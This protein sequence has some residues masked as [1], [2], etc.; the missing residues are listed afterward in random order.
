MQSLKLGVSSLTVSRLAYGCWRIAG[1]PPSASPEQYAAGR[2]A[3]FAA[4]D[5][6]YTL[7]D[8]ADIYGRS[9]AE[10]ILGSALKENPAMRERVCILTKCGV[11]HAGEP[12][13]DSPHRWNFSAD[14]I[15]KS[16][17]ESLRRLGIEH[18]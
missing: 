17:D 11:Q 5:A 16:C 6:G 9:E 10:R 12:R 2:R 1:N 14:H 3:I 15:L 4:Y 18:D 13:A 8:N 7:F